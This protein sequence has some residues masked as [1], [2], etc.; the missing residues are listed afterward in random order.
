MP[1]AAEST[2]MPAASPLPST[3]PMLALALPAAAVLDTWRRTSPPQPPLPHPRLVGSGRQDR[4]PPTPSP[5][6]AAASSASS[7]LAVPGVAGRAARCARRAARTSAT[8]AAAPGLHSGSRAR[9]PQG[10]GSTGEGGRSDW[11]QEQ[12]A[13][14][15]AAAALPH[16]AGA[17]SPAGW[18]RGTCGGALQGRA[19]GSSQGAGRRRCGPAASCRLLPMSLR[20]GGGG[21]GGGGGGTVQGGGP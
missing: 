5:L 4:P 18:P 8:S 11:P 7:M 13:W 15:G 20:A 12:V 16:W 17:C 10:T 1:G 21:A 6:P 14:Q 2:S 19:G 9:P 3:L